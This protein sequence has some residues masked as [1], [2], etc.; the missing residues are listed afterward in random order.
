MTTVERG[1]AGR[2]LLVA[3][4]AA[5]LIYFVIHFGLTLLYVGPIN[6]VKLRHQRL[7][8]MTIGSLFPQNWSFFAPNPMA[9]NQI[10]LVHCV[11]PDESPSVPTAGWYD[12][13][14]PLIVRH[15]QQRFS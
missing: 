6:P 15:Q 3:V 4:K 14:S 10:L 2:A 11:Q 1:P 12:V 5:T 13:S 7:L 8:G 9:S